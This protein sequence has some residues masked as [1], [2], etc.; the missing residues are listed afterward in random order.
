MTDA[1]EPEAG[2]DVRAAWPAIRRGL[3]CRCPNCGE[4]RLFGRFLKVAGS[5]DRCGAEFQHHRADDFPPYLV[6]FVVGHIVVGAMTMAATE[7]D[8]P[9]WVHLAIWP[10]LTLILSLLLIQPIKGGVVAFQW[11]HRM[12]G[13]G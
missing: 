8:W 1:S 9:D 6:I 13:F 10:A 5:C 11:A 3:L 4:G 12:H 7:A 2:G